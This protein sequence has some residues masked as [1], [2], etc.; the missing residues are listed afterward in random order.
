MAEAFI[1]LC[2]IHV[3]VTCAQVLQPVLL[4][5]MHYGE[6]IEVVRPVRSAILGPFK[7]WLN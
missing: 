1:F 6:A 3:G 7:L 4:I 2:P 5:Q